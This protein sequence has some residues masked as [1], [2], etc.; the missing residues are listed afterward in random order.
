MEKAKVAVARCPSYA[1]KDVSVALQKCL[2]GLGGDGVTLLRPKSKVF[3]KINH[4]SPSSHPDRA[5]ITH[6]AFTGEVLRLLKDYEMEI[7]V[8]DDIHSREGDG[9]LQSGYRGLCA[10]LGIRLVNLKE[11]GFIEV[12]VRG[13]VLKSVFIARPVLKADFILNLPKLKTHSFAIF[14]GAVKN[15]YGVIP[16]G[17]R[18]TYHRRFVR[19]SEFSQM[20]VDLLSCIPPQLTIMDAVVG[21]EGEGP[22][23]GSAKNIGLLLAGADAVAVDAVATRLVGYNPFDIY[24]TFYGHQRGLGIGDLSRIEISGERIEDLE[25]DGFK[26]SAVAVGLFRRSLPSLLYA[27]IQ[28]QLALIP[29]VRRDKCTACEECLAICPRQAVSLVKGRAWI[30]EKRCIHC[31]CCHEVCRQRAVRLKQL[32]MGKLIRRGQSFYGKASAAIRKI[33]QPSAS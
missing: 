6:P 30:E 2:H 11:T 31:L 26:H 3:V 27:L 28:D 5:I 21:M 19:N 1:A 14:T 23:A 16:H 7:T 18:L 24:T 17:L 22:S 20:L 29:E 10:D 15:M 9:F 25:V 32:P 12:P 33:I 8:G 13:Q 4:L